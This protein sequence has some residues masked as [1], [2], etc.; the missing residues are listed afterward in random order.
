MRLDNL[1][2]IESE[3]RIRGRPLTEPYL[4]VRIRLIM[5][6]PIQREVTSGAML[7]LK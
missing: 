1:V 7:G 2:P 3:A 6:F 4:R 5:A